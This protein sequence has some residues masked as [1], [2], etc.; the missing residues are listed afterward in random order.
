MLYVNISINLGKTRLIIRFCEVYH[1]NGYKIYDNNNT[2]G[3]KK[4]YVPEVWNFFHY[5]RIDKNTNGRT[6]AIYQGCIF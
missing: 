6:I 4:V 5:S 1:I 2:N 3:E